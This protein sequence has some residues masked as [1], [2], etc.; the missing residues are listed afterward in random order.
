MLLY[1]LLS[2]NIH[3]MDWSALNYWSWNKPLAT[4]TFLAVPKA[5]GMGFCCLFCAFFLQ[6]VFGLWKEGRARKQACEPSSRFKRFGLLLWFQHRQNIQLCSQ[7]TDMQP[8]PQEKYAS[9]LWS[10]LR[11]WAILSL[12]VML[13]KSGETSLLMQFLA[14]GDVL[15]G[16]GP[17]NIIGDA[18]W[19]IY[20]WWVTHYS[21]WTP[22]DFKESAH[23]T[24]THSV[25]KT[26]LRHNVCYYH[27]KNLFWAVFGESLVHLCGWQPPVCLLL[28]SRYSGCRREENQYQLFFWGYTNHQD[29]RQRISPKLLLSLKVADF[30]VP[31][32]ELPCPI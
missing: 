32:S 2:F 3:L 1:K 9:R 31:I 18:L 11:M 28:L 23:S 21:S 30:W 12:Q 25:V 24:R 20:S 10:D 4:G 26:G 7:N 15:F 8:L 16:F 5:E 14:A 27:S 19:C 29:H 13:L 6:Q 22:T 17:L